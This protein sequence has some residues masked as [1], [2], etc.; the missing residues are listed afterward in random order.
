MIQDRSA[1]RERNVEADCPWGDRPLLA[2]S[3]VG[4]VRSADKRASMPQKAELPG[5]G[6]VPRSR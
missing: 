1:A 3:S 5:G 2:V 4:S 6:L